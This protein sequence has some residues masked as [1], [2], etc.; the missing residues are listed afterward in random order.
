MVPGLFGSNQACK[1]RGGVGC[2]T[3]P[4]LCPVGKSEG[5]RKIQGCSEKAISI[6]CLM[7]R[8]N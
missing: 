6:R 2:D 8:K 4:I 1:H 3:P 7:I 5:S